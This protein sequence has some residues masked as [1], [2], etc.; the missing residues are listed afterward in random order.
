[1]IFFTEEL[2]KNKDKFNTLL[3]DERKVITSML[4][5]Q[6]I[7]KD[8][9]TKFIDSCKDSTLE[10]D[11][12]SEDLA[13]L[14][15]YFKKTLELSIS[16]ISILNKLNLLLNLLTNTIEENNLESLNLEKFDEFNSTFSEAYSTIQINT[17][18]IEKDLNKLID[19]DA[20]SIDTI[21]TE[22][23]PEKEP[24]T[25]VDYQKLKNDLP[26][27]LKREN[28]LVISETKQTV[29]LPYRYSELEQIFSANKNKFSSYEEI[30]NSHY[31]IPLSF[32]KNSSISRFKEAFKL[33]K[34][35]ENLSTKDGL[36]LGVEL[37]F[38]Y[39]LHPAIISACRNIDEL[40]I[41][42]DYLENNEMYKFDCFNIVFEV[43]PTVVESKPLPK[44]RSKK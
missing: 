34:T 23:K 22:L 4:D 27:D 17:L 30:I 44:R 26:E 35:K 14:E 11:E 2:F 8:T 12:N 10:D 1:M 28:T 36:E 13:S 38:N 24:E 6:T 7:K 42:L 19:L 39:N 32:F 15:E 3:E 20:T 41:Y 40:D 9:I 21:K 18:K 37:F 16:N 33:V 5:V 31:I 25:I 29:F 43:A